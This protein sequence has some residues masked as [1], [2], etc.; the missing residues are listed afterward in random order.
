MIDHHPRPGVKPREEVIKIN[1]QIDKQI[2]DLVGVFRDPIIVMPGGWGETLPDWIK[3][4]VT[5]ERLVENMKKAQGQ[6]PTGTDA[7]ATAYLYTASL[8]A[9]M[10]EQWTRIYLYVAGKAMSKSNKERK[11]PDDIKVD[12]LSDYDM[13]E[14]NRLKFWLYRQRARARQ[15]REIAQRRQ[16]KEEIAAGVKVAQP[17]LFDF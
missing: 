3:T 13:H 11:I 4:Q 10:T 15:E 16:K 6:E 1:S 7:E 2:D 14:L 17:A 12:S 9:P 5:L 8:T